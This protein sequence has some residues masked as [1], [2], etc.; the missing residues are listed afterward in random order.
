MSRHI[1]VALA[2]L[3]ALATACSGPADSPVPDVP[4]GP[5]VPAPGAPETP[6]EDEDEDIGP[7]RALVNLHL[8]A[9]GASLP[10]TAAGTPAVVRYT[11]TWQPVGTDGAGGTAEVTAGDTLSIELEPGDYEFTAVAYG[12]HSD[13]PLL[14]GSLVLGVGAGTHAPEMPLE[15]VLGGMELFPLVPG[16]FASAG[17]II[18]FGIRVL[19][20]DGESEV[21]A[22]QF[23]VVF[24]TT[25]GSGRLL[26]TGP[27]GATVWVQ[28]GDG[29]LE[30][31]A[32]VTGK[33][34]VDGQISAGATL[35]GHSQLE[36]QNEETALEDWQAPVVRFDPLSPDATVISGTVTDDRGVR[37]VRLWHG[38]QLVASSDSADL[39]DTVSVISF[40]S[41]A[42]GGWFTDWQLP[43]GNVVL[44]AVATDLNGNQ[45]VA[46][47]AVNVQPPADPQ[48]LDSWS[49]L[50]AATGDS[51]GPASFDSTAGY[52]AATDFHMPGQGLQAVGAGLQAVGAVGGLFLAE[53]SAYGG[54]IVP[55]REALDPLIPALRL[56]P[57]ADN[58]TVVI[59]VVD[60]F[61]PAGNDHYFWPTIHA[62]VESLRE[63]Q[64][65]GTLPHGVL[66]A[67]HLAELL[68]RTGLGHAFIGDA[69]PGPHRVFWW[70]QG[71]PATPEPAFIL[72]ML[73]TNGLDSSGIVSLMREQILHWNGQAAQVS[74][75]H[76]EP[77]TRFVINMSFVLL[78]CAVT[79]DLAASG[80]G[81]F[82][83][84]VAAVA[85]VNGADPRQASEAVTAAPAVDP[86]A[87]FFDCPFGNPADPWGACYNEGGPA[88]VE[89]LVPVASAGNFGLDFPLYP[90][91]YPQVIAVGSF[92]VEAGSS[93][94]QS[95]AAYSNGANVLAPG[96]LFFLTSSNSSTRTVG[97]A[98]T[99]FAAPY[100]SVMMAHDLGRN[101]G[102]L[103]HPDG[104]SLGGDGLEIPWLADPSLSNV[105]LFSGY[106]SSG[107]ALHVV[108]EPFTY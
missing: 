76:L 45:G 103:C 101:Q 34:V 60:D 95:A 36:L 17:E 21:P 27:D 33:A 97:Y 88:S 40:S 35:S 59:L 31:S 69:A 75:F 102:F 9:E 30:V 41:A 24:G 43:A 5:E 13:A 96:G 22:G 89:M 32:T 48:D 77:V 56:Q 100:V 3:I 68:R 83:D 50:S 79:D 105:P 94:A 104:R 63:H 70:N 8:P 18:G 55:G 86:F 6:D 53:T 10:V 67:E 80:L 2:I 61:G 108:C 81:S 52:C 82:E 4:A 64:E 87:E 65:N 58:P 28:D 85:V 25:P 1:A 15:P 72:Q 71:A 11:L 107:S 26:S 29:S 84:Y 37:S 39:T 47:A 44:R 20:A 51:S 78:P 23:E 54:R 16:G 98:G 19:A 91:A 90:A 38:Q 73:N 46:Y 49:T 14:H 62:T 57:G 74:G 92:D 93:F 66:V 7:T 42:A 12:A 106:G 99:S